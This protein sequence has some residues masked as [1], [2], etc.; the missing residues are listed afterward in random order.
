[1]TPEFVYGVDF[2]GATDAERN[3]WIAGGRLTDDGLDIGTLGTAKSVLDGDVSGQAET[4]AG[5]V[6]W[7]REREPA[8]VGLDFS[9][10][11]PS[12][13]LDAVDD[14]PADWGAFLDSFPPA[15]CADPDGFEDWGKQRTREATGGER[16]FLKRETDGPVGAS[17]PYGFIG[18]TITYYGVRD[19]LAPLVRGSDG[20]EAVATVAPMQEQSFE[21]PLTLLETYPAGVLGRLGLQRRNYKGASEAEREA[22]RRNLDGLLAAADLTVDDADR[23]TVVE[24]TGGDALDA[25]VAAAA[26][27]RAV[28]SGFAVERGRYDERE[29]YIYV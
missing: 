16:A 28:E 7:L 4:H 14:P 29:G 6:D 20:G 10:G 1:M 22:R 21:A 17:S 3:V 12:T 24:N 11:L 9:F 2:S 5:L 27:L 15:D 18:S 23:E 13:L 8:A 25:V 19:V 26:A